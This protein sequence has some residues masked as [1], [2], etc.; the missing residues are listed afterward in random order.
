MTNDLPAGLD[1]F[2][3]QSRRVDHPDAA[4][5]LSAFYEEQVGRYGFAESVDLDPAAYEPPY[6]IFVVAYREE[7]PVGCGGCRWYDR[8]TGTVEIKKTYLVPDVRGC[9]LG[10]VLLTWLEAEAVDWGARRVILETGV[11]NTAALHLF[12]GSGYRPAP[13]YVAGRDPLINRA[14]AKTLTPAG[15]CD[16][17]SVG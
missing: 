4:L 12:N 3:V 6:G 10:R 5:L 14:F 15:E 16:R 17:A 1:E 7:R 9:G 13:R 2:C 8:A 11:R